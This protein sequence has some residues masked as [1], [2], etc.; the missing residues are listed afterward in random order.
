MEKKLNKLRKPILKT[1]KYKHKIIIL[2][3]NKDN[4]N[5]ELDKWGK[6]GYRVIWVLDVDRDKREYTLE[7]QYK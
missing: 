5:L 3:T 1:T 6:A 4:L 2:N 7:K